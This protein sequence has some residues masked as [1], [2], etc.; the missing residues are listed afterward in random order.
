L[1]FGPA[2]R[3]SEDIDRLELDP[4]D[5]EKLFQSQAAGS[6][7]LPERLQRRGFGHVAFLVDDASMFARGR[8]TVNRRGRMASTRRCW[9]RA[10]AAFAE[11]STELA[12][13]SRC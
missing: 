4:T 6:A 10:S 5:R 12:W 2:G 8:E 9:D 7:R 1:Q 3:V 11:N 13:V